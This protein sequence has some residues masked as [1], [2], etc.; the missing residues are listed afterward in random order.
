M[1]KITIL[2]GHGDW[3]HKNKTFIVPNGLSVHFFCDHAQPAFDTTKINK[4]IKEYGNSKMRDQLLDKLKPF[5][6]E[7]VSAGSPCYDYTLSPPRGVTKFRKV[8]LVKE[9]GAEEQLSK[10]AEK[11]AKD[12][13]DDLVFYAC[14]SIVDKST[15]P[16]FEILSAE[17]SHIISTRMN[18][19]VPTNMATF[20]QDLM[21]KGAF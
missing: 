14:R 11:A 19:V 6:K 3:S 10:F 17:E 1:S 20:Y 15:A 21:L 13:I 2:S 4:I 16:V 12:K 8:A 18:D 9:V 5:I 7:T